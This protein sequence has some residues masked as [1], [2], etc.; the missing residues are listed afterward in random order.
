MEYC[1]YSSEVVERRYPNEP[2]TIYTKQTKSTLAH[3]M[4]WWH[5]TEWRM[6]DYM[7]GPQMTK[8]EFW[9]LVSLAEYHMR[10]QKPRLTVRLPR[11]ILLAFRRKDRRKVYFDVYN[12]NPVVSAGDYFRRMA[13]PGVKEV[14]SRGWRYCQKFIHQL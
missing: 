2:I 8:H 10:G 9:E 7:E 13:E 14:V 11:E 5:R 6:G 1:K 4:H 3:L 12:V